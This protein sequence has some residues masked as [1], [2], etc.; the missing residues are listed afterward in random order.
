MSNQSEKN[1]HFISRKVRIDAEEL[2]NHA[3]KWKTTS[4]NNG[5]DLSHWPKLK[6]SNISSREGIVLK[7]GA[8]GGTSWVDSPRR[9]ENG[10]FPQ[11]IPPPLNRESLQKSNEKDHF[12][13]DLLC[14]SK[15]MDSCFHLSGVQSI[16]HLDLDDGADAHCHNDHF[17]GNEA[18]LKGERLQ[19]VHVLDKFSSILT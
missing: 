3:S 18:I 14:P 9:K 7:H 19:K 15:T 11:S 13:L 8:S 5:E 6:S 1:N 12:H 10:P 17:H 16:L 4:I 2:F